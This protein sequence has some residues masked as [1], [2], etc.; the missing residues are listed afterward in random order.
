[1]KNTS[2][3]YY[4]LLGL[5]L[6]T[7]IIF[8][9]AQSN[10]VGY[11]ETK[12]ELPVFI[13][14]GDYPFYAN[15]RSGAPAPI[16]PDPYSILGNY[17]ITMFHHVSGKYQLITGE[18]AWARFN[19]GD[20]PVTGENSFVVEIDGKTLELTGTKPLTWNFGPGFTK[21]HY[22][23]GD[24]LTIERHISIPPSQ[25]AN[26]GVTAALI[27]ITVKNNKQ[28][29]IKFKLKER[30]RANYEMHAQQERFGR[31]VKKVNYNND[32]HVINKERL[33]Y[34]NITAI[35]L[36]PLLW[37]DKETAA[38]YD[39]FPP[40]LFMQDATSENVIVTPVKKSI[41]DFDYMGLEY[42]ISLKSGETKTIQ[43]VLGFTYNDRPEGIE[44]V[45]NELLN[46][47]NS[48]D[49]DSYSFDEEWK[50]I[51]PN[52]EHVN[53]E[54]L[55]RE[56]IWNS[57]VL[58]AMALYSDYYNETKIPSG[59]GYD[60]HWG[61]HVCVRD[62]CQLLLPWCYYKP[63]T[64]KSGIRYL[65]KKMDM[66]GNLENDEIGYGIVTS[67]MFDQ[68]DNQLYFMWLISEYLRITGDYSFMLEEVNYYP[69]ENS[70]KSNGVQRLI[71]CFRYIREEIGTGPHGMMRTLN[72]DWNDDILFV[73]NPAPYN[74]IWESGE[75]HVNTSMAIVVFGNL[76]EQLYTM[77]K[78]PEFNNEKNKILSLID[79]LHFYRKQ[80]LDAFIK[81]WGER[82]FS[83]RLYFSPDNPF[84]DKYIHILPQ[85]FAM[86]IPE[87][88]LE[89]KKE[90]LAQIKARNL[91]FEKLG[92]RVREDMDQKH[93]APMG[94]GE[95]GAVW[96][97]PS[98]QLILGANTF[99]TT[100]AR[101]LYNRLTFQHFSEVF[102]EYWTS[103]WTS[104]DYVL[105][106]VNV[107]EGT[108]LNLP[109]CSLPHAFLLY[110][111]YKL[112]E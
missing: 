32:I 30:I 98:S 100:T 53:K 95:N 17:R 52:F 97:V 42:D 23:P 31:V 36:E 46:K 76:M 9:G 80:F 18:R 78:D 34:N 61:V 73:H 45:Y 29:N 26:D 54:P 7:N 102:P 10:T 2:A 5:L 77:A 19:Q 40:T 48:T 63:E 72:S 107:N 27:T 13:Y 83:R 33:V 105:S 101:E 14:K 59:T 1:M 85:A 70:S 20:A 84:G 16:I 64:A 3:L 111:H 4:I 62:H 103:Y 12:N 82:A 75:S 47:R 94:A 11:W 51:L 8:T 86:Q 74:R 67:R 88:P 108:Y 66:D 65:M 50:N 96:Y 56:L 87:F 91:A 104:G 39:G 110:L 60:Y 37:E 22:K 58:E 38:E 28:D 71:D 41:K 93:F 43:L 109:F 6:M 69:M 24:D 21:Y 25:K 92:P 35:P 81:D 15:N 57:Y 90:A 99:D 89:K 49:R 55:K 44:S 79:G 68:S 106:S 112:N